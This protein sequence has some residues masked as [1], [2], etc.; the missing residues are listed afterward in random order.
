MLPNHSALK[1]AE[2]FRLLEA[3]HPGRI[4]LGIGRAPGTDGLTAYALRRSREAPSADDFP[5]QMRELLGFL[6]DGFDADHPFARINASP[7]GVEAPSLWMLGSSDFGGRFAAQ[8]GLGFAFAHHINPRPAIATMNA[9]RAGFR[10]SRHRAAPAS[11]LTLSVV[12]A[13]TDDQAEDLAATVDLV[14][15]RVVQGKVRT[16]LPSVEE[17]K[18]YT[19]SPAEEALRLRNRARSVVGGID[20]VRDT[21]VHMV[22]ATCADEVMITTMVHDHGA[23][24]HSY[25][26]LADALAR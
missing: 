3:L 26:L 1:V 20:R 18:S 11:I 17:A 22:G 16:A 25:E 4:D 19:Y 14:M 23:R 2:T 24:R 7:V 10:P 21:I 9:Y 12:C 8:L 15:V 6:G 5:Q 13:D